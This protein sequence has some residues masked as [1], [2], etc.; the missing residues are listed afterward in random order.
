MLLNTH[1]GYDFEMKYYNS[2]G[3][4]SSMCGN[5]GRCL[6]KFAHDIGILQSDY[7]F[8]AIDGEH[9][10][11]V[12]TDGTVA[13]KMLDVDDVKYD[14]GN[15]ILNTGSHHFFTLANDVMDLVVF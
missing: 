5:G 10:A 3:R 6:T 9:E 2:D 4:E 1:A 13:L 11:S 15:F 8:I 12:N 7:K 14:R